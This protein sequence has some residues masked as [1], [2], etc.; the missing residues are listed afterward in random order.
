MESNEICLSLWFSTT[1]STICEVTGQSGRFQYVP[2]SGVEFTAPAAACSSVDSDA[3]PFVVPDV[4]GSCTPTNDTSALTELHHGDPL[5]ATGTH[6]GCL[7]DG[8]W[9]KCAAA[10]KKENTVKSRESGRR[11][12]VVDVGAVATAGVVVKL[13]GCGDGS[14]GFPIRNV[15]RD[16]ARKEVRGCMFSGLARRE[17]HFAPRFNAVAARVLPESVPVLVPI[18]YW[19]YPL[20]IVAP[21]EFL[22]T[23]A[24][25]VPPF[26][27]PCC[28]LFECRGDR[29]ISSHVLHGMEVVL[30]ALLDSVE[31]TPLSLL[32]DARC[33]VG[34]ET[35]MACLCGPDKLLDHSTARCRVLAATTGDQPVHGWSTARLVHAHTP[36]LAH[37][38]VTAL[39][40]AHCDTAGALLALCIDVCHCIGT[41]IGLLL[42]GFHD[43]GLSWGTYS[44]SLAFHCNAHPNNLAVVC[45]KAI[46]RGSVRRICAPVDFDMAFEFS[47]VP[48]INAAQ[49]KSLE[50]SAMRMSLGR[51]TD[52]SGVGPFLSLEKAPAHSVDVLWALRDVLTTS[53]DSAYN[54]PESKA[55][56][57]AEISA[58]DMTWHLVELCVAVSADIIA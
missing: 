1:H 58:S 27:A 54:D 52:N 31:T 18:G 25:S 39:Q 33:G 53:F 6:V 40:V 55:D 11:S 37:Q 46:P 30:L 28:A 8:V 13:K 50:A 26:A 24:A 34:I 19:K 35:W 51:A 36:A 4:P 22:E 49:V 3:S 29:R 44:D 15:G 7:A 43:A 45:P 23:D 17:L 9:R 41:E 42:R 47:A 12:C 2:D 20:G 32:D 21:Q 14:D 5:T 16:R 38:A 10:E 57:A 48:G 56:V